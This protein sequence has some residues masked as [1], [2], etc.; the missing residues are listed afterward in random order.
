[1]SN[2][3]NQLPDDDFIHA[4]VADYIDDNLDADCV[5]R[6]KAAIDNAKYSHVPEKFSQLRGR[7]QLAMQEIE[8]NED[9]LMRIN[10]L[11]EAPDVRHTQEV[12]KIAEVERN[13]W[14]STLRRRAFIIVVICIGVFG[15]VYFNTAPNRLADFQPL[16]VLSYE[17]LA[18]HEDHV[19][20]IALP[21]GE[22]SDIRDYFKRDPS[23]GFQPAVL[24]RLPAEWQPI[25]ATI[26][27]YEVV[28]VTAV[29]FVHHRTGDSMMHFAMPGQLADLP[30]TDSGNY[31]GLIY[32][33]YTQE[34]IQNF[35]A[36]QQGAGVLGVL[37][38]R[39]TDE[40]M[41]AIASV[42]VE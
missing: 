34:G 28:K 36:W 26:I 10:S 30:S 35:I 11:V 12:Q 37:V 29:M 5:Q 27:D 31:R 38:S 19:D 13:V 20:R 24:S 25:G 16:E 2:K 3:V 21:S 6:Y 14:W 1:M 4:Y 23:L 9:Q 32:Q 22:L 42:G 15:V 39:M 40:Q 8:L 17:A 41:A 7:L 33:A 18:F